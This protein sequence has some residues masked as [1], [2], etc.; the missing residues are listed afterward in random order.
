MTPEQLY[1]LLNDI[2]GGS[3]SVAEGV[4]QLAK[5]PFA[6]IGVAKVDHHRHLRTGFPEVVLGEGKSA[7]QIVAIVEEMVAHGDNVLV[8]RVTPEKADA[9]CGRVPTLTHRREA[10]ALVLEQ[11]PVTQ[12]GAGPVFVITAGTADISVAEEACLV[13]ELAGCD[14]RRL[15]DAGVAGIHRLFHKLDDLRSASV[16][17]V[18]AGMEGALASVVGGLVACP[19]IAVP[20]SVGYGASFGGVAALLGMLNSCAAGVT[21]VNIDNGFG[22]GYAA[23]LMS[24]VGMGDRGGQP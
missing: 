21:V 19:V 16:I 13:A 22:A 11:E 17:I 20:T 2:Q 4:Q 7:E 10:R 14:V 1:K 23:V 15:F 6:D 24:R 18:V 8:T 5:L 9:V 12:E 3:V